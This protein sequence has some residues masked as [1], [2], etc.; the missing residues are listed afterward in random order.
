LQQSLDKLKDIQ[1]KLSEEVYKSKMNQRQSGS[2]SQPNS[3][4]AEAKEK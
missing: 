4:D 1:A 2:S 3:E